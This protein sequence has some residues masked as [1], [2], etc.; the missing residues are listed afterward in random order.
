[1]LANASNAFN[2]NRIYMNCCKRKK[3]E[4]DSEFLFNAEGNGGNKQLNMRKVTK[5]IKEQCSTG[6]VAEGYQGLG[7]QADYGTTPEESGRRQNKPNERRL[8][9]S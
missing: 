5:N 3:K 8:G 7:T 9:R 1:M 6:F 2:S 4:G